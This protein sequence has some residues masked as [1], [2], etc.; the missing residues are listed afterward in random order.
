MPIKKVKLLINGNKEAFSK[1]STCKVFYFEQKN[2]N[3]V[4]WGTS[5]FIRVSMS[6]SSRS[7]L[8]EKA[9]TGVI[10]VTDYIKLFF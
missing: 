2:K 4:Y 8:I 10:T 6:I 5:E 9:F 1:N 7:G 3:C